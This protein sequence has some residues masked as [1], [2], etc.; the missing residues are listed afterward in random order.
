MHVHLNYIILQTV[1]SLRN[2]SSV[3]QFNRQVKRCLEALGRKYTLWN[4]KYLNS[5]YYAVSVVF[6]RM[7]VNDILYIQSLW[8]THLNIANYWPCHY[9]WKKIDHAALNFWTSAAIILCFYAKRSLIH[10]NNFVKNNLSTIKN[11]YYIYSLLFQHYLKMQLAHPF[12]KIIL[13]F[14][15]KSS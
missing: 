15:C 13:L 3:I 2:D 6:L 14:T 12:Y 9:T 11:R 10:Y 7:F 4:S 8:Y 5:V 1:P